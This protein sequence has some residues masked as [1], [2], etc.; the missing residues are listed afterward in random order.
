MFIV[1]V[2]VTDDRVTKYYKVIGL[3]KQ[4]EVALIRVLTRGY[5]R[6]VGRGG[7]APPRT[8]LT[9]LGPEPGGCSS[10]GVWDSLCAWF[11]SQRVLLSRSLA[12]A[13]P[14]AQWFIVLGQ[15]RSWA[16]HDATWAVFSWSK[17]VPKPVW[18]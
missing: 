13:S 5:S 16:L 10:W 2:S 9:R 15:Q 17:E 11:L 18:I 14:R 6:S 1:N 12:W 3:L 4:P 8:A 7:C